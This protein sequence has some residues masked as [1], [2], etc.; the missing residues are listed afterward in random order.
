MPPASGVK[1]HSV[2]RYEEL[3][4]CCCHL[5]SR[6]YS[7]SWPTLQSVL[8]CSP[9]AEDWQ[10]DGG[11]SHPAA[12]KTYICRRP[13]IYH[14][15]QRR[16]DGFYPLPP[17]KYHVSTFLQDTLNCTHNI[18]SKRVWNIQFLSL[19]PRN[20][21]RTQNGVA[22]PSANSHVHAQVPRSGLLCV[23]P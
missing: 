11:W 13:H 1:S 21:V 3:E 19:E 4:C 6:N 10:W 20:P 7:K 14:G 18:A 9:E 2:A 17:S 5:E 23:R 22:R 8:S 16:K 15:C 12:V